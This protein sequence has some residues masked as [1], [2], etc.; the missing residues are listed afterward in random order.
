LVLFLIAGVLLA[1]SLLALIR[2]RADWRAK[3]AEA[4]AGEA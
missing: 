4:E 3:L 2:R 1:L